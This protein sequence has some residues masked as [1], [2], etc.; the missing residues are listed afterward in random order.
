MLEGIGAVAQKA[1]QTMQFTIGGIHGR[2]ESG[3]ITSIA[4]I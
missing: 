1:Q 4:A 2:K 3:I